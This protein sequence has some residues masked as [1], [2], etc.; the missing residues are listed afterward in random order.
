MAKS[1]SCTVTC[2]QRIARPILRYEHSLDPAKQQQ[3]NDNDEDQTQPTTREI[4]PGT[5]VIPPRESTNQ[6]QN[7]QNNQNG[8]EHTFLLISK[9]PAVA[10]HGEYREKN[11]T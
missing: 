5:A 2:P 9:N 1:N 3:N 10:K 8:S 6:K 4:T 11:F 7:Q